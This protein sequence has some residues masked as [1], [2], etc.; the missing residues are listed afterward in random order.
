MANYKEIEAYFLS[1]G[2]KLKK[3]DKVCETIAE[4]IEVKVD[5]KGVTFM[6]EDID[7]K[8]TRLTGNSAIESTIYF[9]IWH[10]LI[11]HLNAEEVKDAKDLLK[12]CADQITAKLMDDQV[13]PF[14]EYFEFLKGI[15]LDSLDFGYYGIEG[16]AFAIGIR[17]QI[18]GDFFTNFEIDTDLWKS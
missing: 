10:P 3:V 5:F 1:M 4:F 15:N 12:E 16:N 18:E 6:V 7:W 8:P 14:S 9:Q 17:G 13:N 2:K 11:N